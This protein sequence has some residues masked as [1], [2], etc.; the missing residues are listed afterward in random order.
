LYYAKR[1]WK[2]L[3]KHPAIASAIYFAVFAHAMDMMSTS[4]ISGGIE[5]NPFARHGD[6]SPWL[7]HLAVEKLFGAIQYGLTAWVA[8]TATR[9]FNR[10]L[11]EMVVVGILIYYSFSSL[12]A[13]FSNILIGLGWYVAIPGL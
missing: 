7:T 10:R 6:G 12:D 11:A 1:L 5:S 13:A 4:L 3:R 2:W 9:P 8:Y